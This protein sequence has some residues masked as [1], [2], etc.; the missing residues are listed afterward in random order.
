VSNV[1]IGIIGVILFIGLALA[2]ALFLGPRFQEASNS[3]KASS[4]TQTIAQVANAVHMYEVQEGTPVV[5]SAA[6]TTLGTKT[7]QSYKQLVEGGYLKSVPTNPTSSGTVYV[8]VESGRKY[9]VMGVGID[10]ATV[11][12][13]INRQAGLGDVDNALKTSTTTA[14]GCHKSGTASPVFYIAWQRV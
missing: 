10:D 9:A 2:G 8:S 14:M 13:A 11:C 7:E 3:A 1:L 4:A 6:N 12:R 5:P